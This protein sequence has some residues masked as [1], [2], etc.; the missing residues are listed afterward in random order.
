MEV[1]MIEKYG[2]VYLWYDRKHRRYYVGSHWGTEDDGYVCSSTWMRNSFRRRP[3]D[4][5]RRILTKVHS[6]K[7]DL[8]DEEQRWMSFIKEEEIKPNTD[9]PRY[10][11]L[12]T[13]VSKL[14]HT[15][16]DSSKTVSEKISRSIKEKH[17]DPKFSEKMRKVYD[18]RIGTKLSEETCRK[19]SES[20]K[21]TM[22]GKFPVED[23]APPRL[24][25]EERKEHY[26]KKAKD[27]WS[28][29]T[30]EE[31]KKLGEKISVANRGLQNRLGKTN[32]PEHRKKISEAQKGRK[33]TEEHKAKLKGPRRKR[34]PEERAAQSERIK[35]SW[36]RRKAA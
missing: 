34:T 26:S 14:W 6:N 27:M 29:R 28:N 31:K 5:K 17:R 8:L 3:E 22:A 9:R 30:D 12:R 25:P 36:E 1:T 15:F 11:N 19:K 16:P 33:F 20:M 10:Y 13:T 24:T 35:L 18:S 7:N 4:F 21:V 32:S 23:R 2:F